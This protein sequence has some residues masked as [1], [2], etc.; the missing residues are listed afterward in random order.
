M[1]FARKVKSELCSYHSCEQ[2][3]NEDKTSSCENTDIMNLCCSK[4]ELYG[5]LLFAKNFSIDGISLQTE[6]I[7]VANKT[8]DLINDLFG[9]V[10]TKNSVDRG[11]Q[12]TYEVITVNKGKD[13]KKIF[14]SYSHNINEVALR[15]NRANIE[16]EC[17]CSAFLR[18]VFLA[19]GSV[20]DP[21]KDYHM[22][23]VTPHLK[24]GNDLADFMI[25]NGLKPKTVVR[26]G[27]F[28]VYFKDSSQIEDTLTFMGAVQNSLELMNIKC[29]KDLRNKVNRETN[30]ET[31]NIGKTV[32]AA[33]CQIDAINTLMARKDYDSISEELRE[34]ARVRLENPEDS[35]RELAEK[36]GISRS[37]V[38]HR[39]NKIVEMA[40]RNCG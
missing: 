8:D 21:E 1:T 11:S 9:I 14:D 20:V 19:C 4:A 27:N 2:P 15:I 24:L 29:Y 37:G 28:V 38:N 25:E 33:V 31:A 3:T 32:N 10:V 17:C 35:L 5:L 13:I 23:F 30:C 16:N 6:N 7:D 34:I 22:E 40:G 36:I 39:L 18:G 12:K 26:K